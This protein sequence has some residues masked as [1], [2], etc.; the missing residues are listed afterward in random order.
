LLGSFFDPEDGGDMFLWNVGWPNGLHDVISQK[1][2]V[3][4]T[5]AVITSNPILQ[6]SLYSLFF[7]YISF[8]WNVSLTPNLLVGIYCWRPAEGS[9]SLA[10]DREAAQTCNLTEIRVASI[11]IVYGGSGVH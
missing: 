9:L 5:T 4:V 1:I 7:N 10:S 6:Y 3:F 2:E 8:L 11:T